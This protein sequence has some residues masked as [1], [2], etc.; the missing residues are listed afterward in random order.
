MSGLKGSST[1]SRSQG[2]AA[3][4]AEELPTALWPAAAL[5]SGIAVPRGLPVCHPALWLP[6]SPCQQGGI[7]HAWQRWLPYSELPKQQSLILSD[8]IRGG[9]LTETRRR[10]PSGAFS[11]PQNIVT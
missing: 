3:T 6:A 7:L 11:P 9:M 4:A 2:E 8:L 5:P 10:E 1:L